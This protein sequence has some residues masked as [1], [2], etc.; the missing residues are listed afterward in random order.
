MEMK[1]I[2][3]NAI[4][5]RRRDIDREG[6][7]IFV[8]RNMALVHLAGPGRDYS[9]CHKLLC[10]DRSATDAVRASDRQ[11][12]VQSRY[13]DSSLGL[14]AS[15]AAGSQPRSDQQFVTTHFRLC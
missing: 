10:D 5:V 11:Y 12:P 6:D 9:Q 1:A 8:H 2:A 14:L 3:T 7:A 15:K 13:A 4:P